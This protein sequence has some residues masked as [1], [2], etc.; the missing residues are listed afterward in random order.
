MRRK[1]FFQGSLKVMGVMAPAVLLVLVFDAWKFFYLRGA[2]SAPYWLFEWFDRFY[3]HILAVC[4]GGG[5]LLLV[6]HFMPCK[7]WRVKSIFLPLA[8]AL[9]YTAG[10]VALTFPMWMAQHTVHLQSVKAGGRVYQMGAYP[11]FDIN[12]YVAECDAH[13]VLCRLVYRSNDLVGLRW[14]EARLEY[15]PG[16]KSLQLK[17]PGEGLIFTYPMNWADQKEWSVNP[18]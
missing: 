13:G 18:D 3:L 17:T 6:L 10:A 16:A 9:F 5:V 11:M 12:H 1:R 15:D 14:Q 8:A 7:R 4:V 2:A